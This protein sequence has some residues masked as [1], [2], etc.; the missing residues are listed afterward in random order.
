MA[1]EEK[2]L[3]K[4]YDADQIQVLEGLEAVRKRP[5]MYIGSTSSKGLHHLVWEIVDNAIDEALAGYCDEIVITIEKDNWIKVE[6]NGR[7]IPVDIE[8]KMGRPAVEVIMTV[9][10]AGGKFGGGGYKVSGGLHGVGAS[11]VNALSEVTEVYVHLH[12]KLHYIKFE[13]GD[14]TQELSVIGETDK[15]GSTIRFKADPEIFTETTVYEYDILANRLRELA[16][17]NRGLRIVIADD[18]EEQVRTN[19]YYYEGGIKSYVEH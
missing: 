1:M 16:Y 13:R 7:G 19:T 15:T 6:D 10:H 18:R 9:L 14:V 17:L 12:E 11:V 5:G 4:S 8:K 2:E 3:Q